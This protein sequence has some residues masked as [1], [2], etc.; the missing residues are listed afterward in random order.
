MSRFGSDLECSSRV[1]GLTACVMCA[2][3]DGFAGLSNNKH[4]AL[5]AASLAAAGIHHQAGTF[6]R[7]SRAPLDVDRA[8]RFIEQHGVNQVYVP[9]LPHLCALTHAKCVCRS[10]PVILSVE[11][12]PST[13]HICL[14][15]T[16]LPRF[17]V[18][19]HRVVAAF[20]VCSLLCT[21]AE[22]SMR[23]GSHPCDSGQRL[24]NN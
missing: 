9:T 18:G 13:L 7:T 3:S 23:G 21:C 11:M 4:V 10:L 2:C 19:S 15:S 16:C 8:V 1:G 20:G 17:A 24:G 6:L 5:T 12:A 14:H 22:G